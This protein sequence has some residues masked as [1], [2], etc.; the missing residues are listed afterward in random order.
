MSDKNLTQQNWTPWHN[1]LHKAILS[2]KTLIPNGANILI[3]VS[4][5]QDSMALLNLFCDIK[6]HHN[7]SISVWHGNHQWHK[8]SSKYAFELNNYCKKKNIEFYSDKTLKENISSEGK[9]R[10]WRYEK[11]SE[12]AKKLLMEEKIEKNIY[13]LTGHTN[14]DNAE[15]FLLNLAR[16]SSYAG[17]SHI[18]QKR[19]LER[20][21]FLIRPILIF[22]REDTKEFCK[23]MN[24]PVWEDPTNSDLKIKRNLVRQKIIPTL[25]SIYPGCS[26][27]INNFAIK[28]SNYNNERND[29]GKLA[30]LCCTDKNGLNR[31]L[32][33]SLCLEARSTI[34]NK[35]LKENCTK[36][37]NSNHLS[38]I[39]SRIFNKNSGKIDLPEGLKI[40]WDKN[41]IN[42]ERD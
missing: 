10:D 22:S 3:A 17:L 16:G 15:T 28:M 39:A 33:N 30:S 11:L 5:G 8:Q 14:T 37:L 41:Y 13:I 36:Q 29:L 20:N 34:L 35:F 2:N 32:L 38:H 19:L 18:K 12:R 42:I 21:I 4:G 40:I 6:E 23:K 24:I 7:W 1:L 26:E 31:N 9:A 25:E 27:R